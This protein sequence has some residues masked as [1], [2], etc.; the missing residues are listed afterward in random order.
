MDGNKDVDDFKVTLRTEISISTHTEFC[1]ELRQ[2]RQ[3]QISKFGLQPVPVCNAP[4]GDGA[5][6]A[7]WY[8]LAPTTDLRATLEAQM[9]RGEEDI[10]S[11]LLEEVGEVLD[12]ARA[13]QANPNHA[14]ATALRA[15]LV[16]VATVCL[17]GAEQV[18]FE[19]V[20][21]FM[22]TYRTA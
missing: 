3:R 16:Q 4:P 2:E 6:T 11:I 5:A 13:Y 12:A 22:A 15:E 7:A 18:A 1:V 21:A 10:M 8:G 19:R 9:A 17:K 14:T 20:L